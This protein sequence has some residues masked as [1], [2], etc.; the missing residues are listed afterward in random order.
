VTSTSSTHKPPKAADKHT[1]AKPF[2][3]LLATEEEFRRAEFNLRLN[4]PSSIEGRALR[5]FFYK[6]K[7]QL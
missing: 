3:A 5:P 7:T 6:G 1:P 2:D 4:D